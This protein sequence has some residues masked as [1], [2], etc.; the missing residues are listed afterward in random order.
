MMFNKDFYPTPKNLVEKMIS[1]ID[2]KGYYGFNILEPSAGKG[3]ILD[4]LLEKNRYKSGY[5]NIDCIEVEPE[6]RSILKGKKYRVV[7]DDFL[8]FYSQKKYDLILMNPPFSDGED[9]K[10]TRLNSSH[11]NISYAVFC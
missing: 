6:L 4:V 8:S 10:S 2:M 3:D 9:R 11:A 1:K 7:Y 5:L